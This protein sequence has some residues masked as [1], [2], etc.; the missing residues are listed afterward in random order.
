M[1]LL[2][3]IITM[4][5]FSLSASAQNYGEISGQLKDLEEQ[6]GIPQ[7]RMQLSQQGV[8]VMELVTDDN[9]GFVFKP[10]NPGSYDISILAFGYDTAVYKSIEVSSGA[11]NFQVFEITAGVELMETIIR[12]PLVDKH[13]IT[14]EH[15][16]DA[17][18]LKHRAFDGIAQAASQAPTVHLSERSGGLSIGGSREDA[19]LYVVDG[20]RVIGSLYV[21]INAIQ[22]LNII[23]GGIPAAYGDVT[24]GIVEI[25]TK[26]YAGVY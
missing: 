15:K 12:P 19:T 24:G 23:T 21:P 9:G 25:T 18:D 3:G 13:D 20:V 8:T 1:R 22:E 17:T 6:F 5:I 2:T 7:A 4:L 11:F 10:L 26:G 14:T 16:I